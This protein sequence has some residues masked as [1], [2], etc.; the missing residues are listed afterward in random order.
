MEYSGTNSLCAGNR[1]A[2]E[3]MLE[4]GRELYTY[5]KNLI[6]KYGENEENKNMLQVMF[7]F[8]SFQLLERADI[9]L[10]LFYLLWLF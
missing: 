6:N 3:R 4:F 7:E 10:L 1:P 8:S 5:N 2:I 9:L